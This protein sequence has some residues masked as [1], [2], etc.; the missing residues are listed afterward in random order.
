MGPL[1]RKRSLLQLQSTALNV[2]NMANSGGYALLVVC[3][4]SVPFRFPSFK[5]RL[6]LINLSVSQRK[7]L[8]SMTFFLVGF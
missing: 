6:D 8:E 4:F 3:V 5:S 2:L 7:Y 1:G